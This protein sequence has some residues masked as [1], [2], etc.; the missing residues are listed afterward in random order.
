MRN[1]QTFKRRAYSSIAQPSF[2]YVYKRRNQLSAPRGD[3]G[4]VSFLKSKVERPSIGSFR[5]IYTH[6]PLFLFVFECLNLYTD[7]CLKLCLSVSVSTY[8]HI[9]TMT[10]RRHVLCPRALVVL[11]VFFVRDAKHNR[12]LRGVKTLLVLS[13]CPGVSL[14]I[15]LLGL[16]C[17]LCTC[18]QLYVRCLCVP[19]FVTIS[20]NLTDLFFDLS[21]L[22][23]S[24]SS[25]H[26]S[27]LSI[28]LCFRWNSHG[29]S[30]D[31]KCGCFFFLAI[32]F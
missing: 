31:N 6:P 16:Q 1:A 20:S 18:T 24:H 21:Q 26:R 8:T 25:M 23:S 15:F 3:G 5:R 9:C 2:C 17:L 22:S 29:P 4:A 27:R 13:S 32:R 11:V 28:R 10:D 30:R 7:T 14:L 12:H 19:T